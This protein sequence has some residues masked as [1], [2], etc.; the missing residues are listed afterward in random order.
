MVIFILVLGIPLTLALTGYY[1]SGAA[2]VSVQNPKID[3]VIHGEA[4]DIYRISNELINKRDYSVK[5]I[6][7]SEVGQRVVTRIGEWR[8]TSEFRPFGS[9]SS[10]SELLSLEK[11]VVSV[12]IR[13]AP[14]TYARF[15][16]ATSLPEARVS[17]EK[18][19]KVE[20]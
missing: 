14:S 19:L 15:V 16:G 9:S 18:V 17:V 7:K 1:L 8:K 11:K 13:V 12:E 5:V 10:E 2:G 3:E 4:E 20:D 6:T